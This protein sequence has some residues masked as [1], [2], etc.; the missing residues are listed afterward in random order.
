MFCDTDEE[1]TSW[2]AEWEGSPNRRRARDGLDAW[3]ADLP[4]LA[5]ELP[6]QRV[7]D[8]LGYG[9]LRGLADAPYTHL[10]ENEISHGIYLVSRNFTVRPLSRGREVSSGSWS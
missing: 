1:K 4:R 8:A 5:A 9:E 6:V 10:I 3:H 7:V 2:V